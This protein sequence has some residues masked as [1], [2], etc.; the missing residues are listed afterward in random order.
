MQSFGKKHL[1]DVEPLVNTLE[2]VAPWCSIDTSSG[3]LTVILEP[4]NC[5]HAEM[6][7]DELSPDEFDL[8]E[9]RDDQRINLGSWV[10]RWLFDKL[11]EEEIRR[12][13]VYRAKLN[14][15]VE[16]RLAAAAARANPPSR[17]PLPQPFAHDG[18]SARAP[19]T[20]KAK[21]GPGH[22][23]PTT[24][25]LAIGLATPAPPPPP[26]PGVP[27]GGATPV[28][29]LNRQS[30]PISRLSV[31][32]DDY[33]ANAIHSV[34]SQTAVKAP[35]TPAVDSAE[36]KAP[37]TPLT[38]NAKDKDKDNGKAHFGKKFRMGMSFGSK[39]LGRSASQS[40]VEKPA[41]VDERAEESETSSTTG[42]GPGADKDGSDDDNFQ[43]GVQTLRRDYDR[44][45]TEAPD[46][47]VA[48]RIAPAP[49][50]DAPRLP[51]P[52]GTRVI[53]Q[54]E[55]SGGSA[56]LYR[57]TVAT[58][59]ADAD[60][61]EARGPRWLADVL[62]VNA[63]PPKEPVKVSF[64]LHPWP[65]PGGGGPGALPPLVAAAADG[66][67]NSNTRLNA[68]RMLRV[69]KILAY[70][71]ERIDPPPED[72]NEA[73]PNALRPEEYLELYCNDQVG[74]FVF[75]LFTSGRLAAAGLGR[76]SD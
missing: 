61:I 17:I 42:G 51:I 31:E 9:F 53:L 73:D 27:E 69:K 37:K 2:A 55:T 32:K 15:S 74:V 65:P 64:V 10:L 19:T 43:G 67:S 12:D 48:S 23:H 7:A 75:F 21:N 54:E 40:A 46:R 45:L 56:E 59:G 29:Q 39:K 66:N 34:E 36:D 14:E 50:N 26:L 1:E 30:S 11:I 18:G 8:G 68:N 70:V 49:P 20:P 47:P 72:P 24:P 52:P 41:V 16:K 71:A 62:L 58:T 44:Q 76:A 35:Q 57:G 22:H 60:D 33:F 38:E 6:Y 25:G 13:E 28:N 63:L 5:F 3:N 4:F